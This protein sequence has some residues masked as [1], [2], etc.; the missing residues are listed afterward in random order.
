[1]AVHDQ[2]QAQALVQYSN[3]A[4]VFKNINAGLPLN[5]Y[6]LPDYIYRADMIPPDILSDS[7]T[8]RE[9]K[10]MLVA[11][12]L[13]LTFTHGYPS[14]EEAVPFWERLP[15][16]PLEAYNTYMMFMEMPEKTSFEVPVRLLHHIA[17]VSNIE[18]SRVI[19]WCHVYYWH[20]RSRA[21][22]LFIA[23]SHRKQREH[24][25]MSIEGKHFMLAERYLTAVDTLISE[26]LGRALKAVQDDEADQTEFES[27]DIK[28][29]VDIVDKLAKVQRIS[30][31]LPAN[32][33]T[34]VAVSGEIKHGAVGDVFKTVA[35]EATPDTQTSRRSQQMDALLANPDDLA[36]VQDLMTRLAFGGDVQSTTIVEHV[37]HDDDTIDSDDVNDSKVGSN[38]AVSEVI[39]EDLG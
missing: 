35:K 37:E 30:V 12:S 10:D 21:Y 17:A 18:L 25:I 24:R 34:Q 31:G 29:L 16:E 20:W 39:V 22:D 8:P 6:G 5:D 7:Y 19:E 27:L 26:K 3:K 9:R 28:G 11:A 23:A 32:G 36:K 15:S 4:D 33:S 13:Q 2:E 14:I 38:E 1:M